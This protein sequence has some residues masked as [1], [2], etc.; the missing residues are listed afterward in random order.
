M[1][2]DNY[3][4]S[5]T[6]PTLVRRILNMLALDWHV[7]IRH[8]W[9]EGNHFADRLVNFSLSFDSLDSTIVKT[10]ISDLRK[11][12]FDDFSGS[13]MPRNVRWVT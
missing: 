12:L 3:K 4:F 10:P 13:S 7:Q 8:T 2:M 9:R 1:I 5:G 11:F 6:A